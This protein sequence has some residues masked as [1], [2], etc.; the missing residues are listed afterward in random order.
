L[1]ISENTYSVPISKDPS[2]A[3][4]APDIASNIK[5]SSKPKAHDKWTAPVRI[6]A[7]KVSQRLHYRFPNFTALQNK[8]DRE[9]TLQRD[10]TDNIES[11]APPE[12]ELRQLALWGIEIFGPTEIDDLYKALKQLGWDED[13]LRRPDLG[14]LK[15]ITEQRMYG[16]GG[17]LNLGLIQRQGQSSFTPMGRNGPIPDAVDYM[18]GYVHQV[19]PSITAVILCFVLKDSHA[20]QYDTALATDQATKYEANWRKGS[21]SGLGVEH[22]KIRAVDAARAKSRKIVIDWFE[23]HLPGFFSRTEDGNRLP[24]AELITSLREPLLPATVELER[25]EPAWVRYLKGYRFRSTWTLKSFEGLSFSWDKAEDN[26]RYHTLINLRTA[27]LSDEHLKHIGDRGKHV[28]VAFASRHIKGVLLHFAVSS[29]LREV[30]RTLRLTR[31]TLSIETYSHREVL[32]AL[33]HIKKFFDKSIGLPT[34]TAELVNKSETN[35]F[36]RWDCGEFLS[37][38]SGAGE[39]PSK[40]AETLRANTHYLASRALAQE[41]ETREHLEQISTILSTQ[42][43]VRAQKRMETVTY[44]A[45]IVAV[46]SLF[47]ALMSVDRFATAINIQVERVFGSK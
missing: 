34:M 5:I 46:A 47:V 17:S 8:E 1:N 36:Y 14:P 15:W 6:W 23:A 3:I 11:R 32:L 16:S 27:L 20:I 33:K 41:K 42:Q 29:A 25:E 37:E 31:D 39:P 30:I 43:S 45:T 21:Y 24:T 4:D 40:I 2:Q 18:H 19:S 22:L 7:H 9:Y 10:L 44:V 13:H 28:Y 12:E 38:P 26:N 35:R